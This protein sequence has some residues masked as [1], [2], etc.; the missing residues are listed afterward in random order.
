MWPSILFWTYSLVMA[1]ALLA[2]LQA[3]R[4]R[5]QLARHKRAAGL[6]VVL[7]FTGII[8]VLVV[9][10][11]FD[12]RVPQRSPDIVRIHRTLAILA[13]AMTAVMAFTGWRRIKI[14][15]RLWP[16]FFGLYI[17]TLATA[18]IGYQP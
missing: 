15:T 14:H 1:I 8:V 11:L 10:Y 13:A 12:I 3:F 17:A 16:L 6:G 2:F 18:L 5:K 9:T 7:T 4:V